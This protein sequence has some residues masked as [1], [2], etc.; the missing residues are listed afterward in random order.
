M[1]RASTPPPVVPA[2]PSSSTGGFQCRRRSP[3]H[4]HRRRADHGG[5]VP[6]QAVAGE[7]RAV[8]SLAARRRP[9]V[10]MRRIWQAVV[11]EALLRGYS[12]RVNHNRRNHYDHG[13]LVVKIGPDDFPIS[14]NGNSAMPMRLSILGERSSWRR[15]DDTWGRRGRRLDHLARPES[16][17]RSTPPGMPVN[18]G[19]SPCELL[20]GAFAVTRRRPDTP[21]SA[22]SSAKRPIPLHAG[23]H[24]S[25]AGYPVRA[26]YGGCYGAGGWGLSGGRSPS[27]ARPRRRWR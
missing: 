17:Q 2:R 13:T 12:V 7:V 5:R 8:H 25:S 14:L 19:A 9:I 18:A 6:G 22:I 16:P 10:R 27:C 21:A 24:K 20:V 4:T 11:A 1:L 15:R 26:G 3:T 23:L